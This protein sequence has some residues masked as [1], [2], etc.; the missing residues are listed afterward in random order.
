LFRKLKET[1]PMYTADA[2][3][4]LF[5]QQQDSINARENKKK[6]ALETIK[7]IATL[8]QN[9]SLRDT[10]SVVKSIGTML[11]NLYDTYEP[12]DSSEGESGGGSLP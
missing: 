4:A 6:L 10:I 2:I 1:D 11:Q 7:T 12:E 8:G 5:V 9:S 3:D